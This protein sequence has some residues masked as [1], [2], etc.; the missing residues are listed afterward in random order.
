MGTSP[1]CLSFSSFSV[2]HGSY[3][4]FLEQGG[5]GGYAVSGAAI[6]GNAYKRGVTLGKG[7]NAQSGH[8][9]NVNGG[10]VE[11]QGGF[12]FNSPLASK[13]LPF[14]LRTLIILTLFFSDAG[15]KG[16][17]TL[18][19]VAVGGNG[20]G[21]GGS[22][23]SGSTGTSNGGSVWNSGNVVVNGYKASE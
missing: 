19:G 13:S 22:A 12:V 23:L 11:N 18:S 14:F 20:K 3:P 1:V 9:G 4:F 2:F 10:D 6:G 15:G 21:G 17:V 7:G 16:G 8:S 5:D